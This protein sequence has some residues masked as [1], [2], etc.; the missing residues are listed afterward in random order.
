MIQQKN[1]TFALQ[2]KLSEKGK[3][4]RIAVAGLGAVGRPLVEELIANKE[5]NAQNFE[6]VAVSARRKRPWMKHLGVEFFNDAKILSQ[7][8]NIDA[9]IEV[10]GGV[11]TAYDV[12]ST[13]LSNG[14]HVI[15]SN[16]TLMAV[17]GEQLTR[18][19]EVSGAYIG[20]DAAI[21]S[22]PFRHIIGGTYMPVN[23]ISIMFSGGVSHGMARMDA[24]QESFETAFGKVRQTVPVDISGKEDFY[25]LRLIH[26]LAYNDWRRSIKHQPMGLE[27]WNPEEVAIA[28]RMGGE[29]QLVGTAGASYVSVQP[30]LVKSDDAAGVI[31]G[32]DHMLIDSDMGRMSFSS[33]A[34]SIDT[35]VKAIINDIQ[36]IRYE[37]RMWKKRPSTAQAVHIVEGGTYFVS[38]P[39]VSSEALYSNVRW[40]VIKQEN[41]GHSGVCG[42]IIKTELTAAELQAV[43][44]RKARIAQ[45]WGEVMER[46]DVVPLKL[47]G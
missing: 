2:Q 43:L 17:Y 39:S 5:K 47:V 23:K 32:Q 9:I 42:A 4:L 26:A 15:T 18:V 8:P 25:R 37:K 34:R 1:T 46:E 27:N 12:V 45:V 40:N 7:L 19:A 36:A 14:K 13:A 21:G 20:F 28:R 44:G 30:M 38:V 22:L 16:A 35:A 10:I 11:T 3:P 41:A 6:I 31:A 24:L 29:V 33:S